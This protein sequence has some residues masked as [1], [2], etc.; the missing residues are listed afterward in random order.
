MQLENYFEFIAEDAIRLAGTRVG[1]ETIIDDYQ[2]GAMPEEIILRY[3]TL[4]LEQVYATITYYLA[5][6]EEVKA[7]ITLVRQRQKDAWQQQQTNPSPFIRSLQARLA[8]QRQILEE[9]EELP[10]VRTAG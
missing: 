6:K 7:Y 1:I 5:N 4:S 3:P 2:Q 8:A 9:Q 10:L